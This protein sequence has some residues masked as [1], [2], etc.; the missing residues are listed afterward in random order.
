MRD[1]SLFECKFTKTIG[2][3]ELENYGVK[4]ADMLPVS[5]LGVLQD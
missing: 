1:K 3:D 5:Y 4:V 2:N